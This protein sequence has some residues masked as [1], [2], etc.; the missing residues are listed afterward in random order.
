[1]HALYHTQIQAELDEIFF[2]TIT[3]SIG[4][5]EEAIHAICNG[6]DEKGVEQLLV[7][8]TFTLFWACVKLHGPNI[9]RYRVFLCTVTARWARHM[10]TD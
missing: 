6:H 3:G 1:M 4:V 9:I 2:R 5:D 10:R 7:Y 8:D